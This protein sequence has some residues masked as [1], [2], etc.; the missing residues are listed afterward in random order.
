MTAFDDDDGVSNPPALSDGRLA[1]DAGEAEVVRQLAALLLARG[2]MM[3]AAE[4]CTGGLV[5]GACTELAGSS[6][7]FER[8]FVTYSNAAKAEILGVAYETLERH[9]AV[10]EPVAREMAAAAVRRSQAQVA[11]AVSGVAGPG[12]GTADKPVGM[13]C[14]GYAVGKRVMTETCRFPGDRRAVRL[15]SVVHVLGRL[16]ELVA[17]R[18]VAS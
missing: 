6:A 4:S 1:R 13:V 11:V 14:F 18:P 9:G 16:G 5:A 12:G 2:W 3:A 17:A 8:G 10:S 7:W 15:A